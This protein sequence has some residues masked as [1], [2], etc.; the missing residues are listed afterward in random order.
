MNPDQVWKVREVMQSIATT[1]ILVNNMYFANITLL[2]DLWINHTGEVHRI[3]GK[4]MRIIVIKNFTKVVR[5]AF[6]ERIQHNLVT[7]EIL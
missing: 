7:D 6:R 5:C 3:R 2:W 1:R 4:G